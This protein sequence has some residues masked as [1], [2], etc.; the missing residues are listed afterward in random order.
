VQRFTKI[1]AWQ[2]AHELARAVHRAASHFPAAER[3]G[4]GADVR[5]AAREV[6][7]LIAHGSKLLEPAE[8]AR[9][10]NRAE[11]ALARAESYLLLAVDLGYLPESLDDG[12]PLAA[13]DAVARLLHGLRRSVE[14]ARALVAEAPLPRG[15]LDVL[16]SDPGR[17]Q[18]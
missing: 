18:P 11:A 6:P 3:Y 7:A 10:L 12:P 17:D 4:L 1:R 8:Y 2:A 5:R 9:H 16:T 15:P 14:Q 13:L